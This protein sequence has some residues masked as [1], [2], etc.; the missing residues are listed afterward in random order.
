MKDKETIKNLQRIVLVQ[1]EQLQLLNCDAEIQSQT[2]IEQVSDEPYTKYIDVWEFNKI[3]DCKGSCEIS[4]LKF[5]NKYNEPVEYYLTR[6][7]KGELYKE[8]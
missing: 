5:T 1:R 2:E 4:H 3:K 8:N 6:D 7:V